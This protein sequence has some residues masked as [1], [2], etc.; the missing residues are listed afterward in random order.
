MTYATFLLLFLV[1]PIVGLAVTLKRPVRLGTGNRAVWTLPAIAAIAFTYTTPWDNYLVYRDVWW[2]GADRVVATIGYVP[3]EE[4][5]FFILQPIFTGLVA[6]HMLQRTARPAQML[7]GAGSRWIGASV[8]GLATAAGVA[9]LL[10]DADQALYMGLILAWASPVLLALWL[11][12][13]RHYWAYRRVF[14]SSV[15]LPTLYL[16]VADRIAIGLGI[17]D[18]S[19]TYSFDFDPLGLP[20]EEAT[21][22]LVT[23]LLVVQGVLLFLHGDAIAEARAQQATPAPAS[24]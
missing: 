23:N 4:Y 21:F 10:A 17:W 6:Y 20:I 18:I 13:G 24:S 7:A 2:Y 5:T 11:F 8:Y 15:A 19:N 9:C 1:L 22:F 3:I 12:G 14:F 16:W